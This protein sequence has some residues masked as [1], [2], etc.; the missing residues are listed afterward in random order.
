MRR[1]LGFILFLVILSSC[2]KDKAAPYVEPECPTIISYESDIKPI[3]NTS[4]VTNMGPGTGCHDGWIFE[5]DNLAA[6]ITNGT[7]PNRV[8]EV[9]DMP[10]ISETFGTDSLTA[11]ELQTFKC[12]VEQGYPNN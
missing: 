11:E 3:I 4:C 8:F 7:T 2:I 12:W 5:Y 10:I 9:R 1:L 6:T